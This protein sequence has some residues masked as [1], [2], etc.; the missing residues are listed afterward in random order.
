MEE[1]HSKVQNRFNKFLA[2][3]PARRMA[4]H[5][6]NL[7]LGQINNN[8]QIIEEAPGDMTAARWQTDSCVSR[9]GWLWARWLEQVPCSPP[10]CGGG[11]EDG[12]QPGPGEIEVAGV[13]AE[14]TWDH[15]QRIMSLLVNI[16]FTHYLQKYLKVVQNTQQYV[17]VLGVGVSYNFLSIQFD[18]PM[19]LNTE[20]AFLHPSPVFIAVNRRWLADSPS[21]SEYVDRPRKC[22]VATDQS[23]ERNV[24]DLVNTS[25]NSLCVPLLT[26]YHAETSAFWNRNTKK[27][28]SSIS[29]VRAS[30]S[31]T[32]FM[33]FNISIHFI[34]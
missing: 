31:I 7:Q 2:G 24:T 16:K 6:I 3:L 17:V 23:V 4:E 13:E 34:V 10:W 25:H 27:L 1:L 21:N 22:Y 29:G 28:L 15:L 9:P 12:T 5:R 30:T 18:G 14:N 33:G 11:S 19:F 26:L 20:A 8:Y 32:P